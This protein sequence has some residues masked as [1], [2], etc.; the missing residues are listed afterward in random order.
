MANEIEEFIRE[1]GKMPK[2]L[3]SQLRPGLRKAGKVVADD[4]KLRSGWSARIPRATRVSVTFS[5]R[6]P[7]VSV[8]VNKNKAPNARPLEHQG[9]TG[10]FRHPVFGKDIWVAQRARPFLY[11]ALRAKGGAAAAEIADVVDRVTREAGFR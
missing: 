8:V 3:R 11:P 7:G 9:R 1:F 2:E 4:V 10:T 5:G 6:R